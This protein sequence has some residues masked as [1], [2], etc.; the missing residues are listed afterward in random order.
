MGEGKK[1]K[2]LLK[3]FLFHGNPAFSTS[4]RGV[5]EGRGV[6]FLWENTP[7]LP[8]CIGDPPLS[9]EGI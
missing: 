2:N 4:P 3:H 7:R 9:T 8:D 6:S 1:E 5:A